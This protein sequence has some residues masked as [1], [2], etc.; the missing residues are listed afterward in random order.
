MKLIYVLSLVLMVPSAFAVSDKPSLTHW[1][2]I[3]RFPT[4]GEQVTTEG[5]LLNASSDGKEASFYIDFSNK[6]PEFVKLAGPLKDV[7]VISGTVTLIAES[8]MFNSTYY[9]NARGEAD[10]SHATGKTDTVKTACLQSKIVINKEELREVVCY[11]GNDFF[12]LYLR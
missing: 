12:T 10:I 11:F 7:T 5:S 9:G 1:Y 3:P 2:E 8:E 4:D 6:N